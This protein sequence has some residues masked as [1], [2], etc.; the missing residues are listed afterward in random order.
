MSESYSEMPPSVLMRLKR[1]GS[2]KVHR[3]KFLVVSWAEE[4]Q[5]MSSSQTH[6]N[7]LY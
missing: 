2:D 1:R 5:R 7:I 4:L 3:Q 6:S